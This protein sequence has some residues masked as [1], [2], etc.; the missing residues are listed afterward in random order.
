MYCMGL[1]IG[2]CLII[3]TSITNIIIRLTRCTAFLA[4]LQEEVSTAT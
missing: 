4:L 1:D 3:I 2:S